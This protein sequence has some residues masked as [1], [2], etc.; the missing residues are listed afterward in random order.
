VDRK[1]V[2]PQRF[3][4]LLNKGRRDLEVHIYPDE[5]QRIL[6][7]S[8]PVD[9]PLPCCTLYPGSQE[10]CSIEGCGRCSNSSKPNAFKGPVSNREIALSRLAFQLELLAPFA[11]KAAKSAAEHTSIIVSKLNGKRTRFLTTLLPSDSSIVEETQY[12]AAIVHEATAM[13]SAALFEGQLRTLVCSARM[14]DL[15]RDSILLLRNQ[16]EACSGVFYSSSRFCD[17]NGT[18]APAAPSSAARFPESPPT[19]RPGTH[20]WIKEQLKDVGNAALA[21]SIAAKLLK[22]MH[23]AAA[24]MAGAL[25]KPI[26]PP[27]P[28]PPASQTP[29]AAAAPQQLTGP[30][31]PHGTHGCQGPG[32]KRRLTRQPPPEPPPKPSKLRKPRQKQQ[33]RQWRRRCRW[34]RTHWLLQPRHGSRQSIATATHGQQQQQRLSSCQSFKPGWPISA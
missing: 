7:W 8:Q 13:A 19:L 10:K 20:E 5:T 11:A 18:R 21:A 27:P 4:Y 1:P 32:S 15:P 31:G 16:M 9:I 22:S 23:T 2:S 33:T 28:P 12:S 24:T 3:L 14:P 6:L 26:P 25:A 34:Q 30:P 29:T 17:T